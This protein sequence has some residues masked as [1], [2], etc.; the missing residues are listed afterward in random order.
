MPHR[1]GGVPY[2]LSSACLGLLSTAVADA[3]HNQSMK[4]NSVRG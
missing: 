1:V 4:E 3:I 2:V